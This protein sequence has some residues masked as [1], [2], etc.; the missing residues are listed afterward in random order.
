MVVADDDLAPGRPGGLAG[1]APRASPT[2]ASA[3]ASA[4]AGSW[5]RYL[6]RAYLG[7]GTAF[8]DVF[9]FL[10]ERGWL[11]AWWSSRLVAVDAEGPDQ[12]QEVADHLAGL[13]AQRRLTY[14]RG[15]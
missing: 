3:S 9:T 10:D 6:F 2:S 8:E 14:E 15:E 12:A 7:A 4:S 13:E 11:Q 1:S 5:A